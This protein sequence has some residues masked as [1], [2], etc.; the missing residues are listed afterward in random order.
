MDE[1]CSLWNNKDKKHKMLQILDN[2]N[3]ITQ[4][5]QNRTFGG[6][7]RVLQK[8]SKALLEQGYECILLIL[9]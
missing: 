8:N 7:V 1:Y 6:G 5:T 4:L 9:E 3:K 2:L